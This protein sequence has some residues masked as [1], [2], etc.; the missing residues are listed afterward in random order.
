[1][2]PL[3]AIGIEASLADRIIGNDVY[4]E[5]IRAAVDKLMRLAWKKDTGVAR[6]DRRYSVLV[7]HAAVAGDDVIELP[8]R[9]MR[10]IGVRRF[11]RWDTQNFDIEGMALEGSVESRL[12]PSP[13]DI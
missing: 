1:M 9:A 7:P 2:A 11:A 10:M 12:R 8:L 5:S 13:S 4:D 6:H 3:L